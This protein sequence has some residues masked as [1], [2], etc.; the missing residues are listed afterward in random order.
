MEIASETRAGSIGVDWGDCEFAGDD[1]L[2]PPGGICGGVWGGGCE[3]VSANVPALAAGAF[4]RIAG[5]GILAATARETM[6][7]EA[8]LR[9]RGAVVGC[10]GDG[11]GNDP[12]SAGDCRLHR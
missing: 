12:V 9:E 7:S 4:R 6:L 5:R 10:R 8:E 1:W 2:L 3:R 11:R